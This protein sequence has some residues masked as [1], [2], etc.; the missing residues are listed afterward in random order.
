MKKIA[1]N[2]FLMP[3][4]LQI[5]KKILLNKYTHQNRS[6]WNLAKHFVWEEENN[7]EEKINLTPQEKIGNIDWCK[8]GCEC[9][10]WRHLLKVSAYCIG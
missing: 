9:N 10:Q 8:C 1:R 2:L 4:T 7:C 3:A 6:I 5:S